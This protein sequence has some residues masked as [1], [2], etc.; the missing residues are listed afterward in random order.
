MQPEFEYGPFTRGAFIALICLTPLFAILAPAYLIHYFLFLVFLGFGLRPVLVR[1]GLYAAWQ[2]FEM[3]VE[4]KWNR[5]F[6]EKR[7]MEIERKQRD[8]KYR[9]SR[10]RDPRLPKNW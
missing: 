5:K 6:L 8:E 1:T 3:T 2:A 10:Y 7:R 9:K 4:K